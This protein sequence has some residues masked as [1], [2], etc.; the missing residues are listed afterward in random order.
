MY[1]Y[2]VGSDGEC[3]LLEF[4]LPISGR[5]CPIDG[6][7]WHNLKPHECKLI[8]L[9]S[10]ICAAFNYNHTN[11]DCIHFAVPC[12]LARDD[13]GMDFAVLTPQRDPEQCYEWRPI[14][15]RSFS[16]AVDHS[17]GYH[18]IRLFIDGRYYVGYWHSKHDEC[19]VNDGQLQISVAGHSYTCDT[20]WVKDGCTIYSLSYTLGN[21]IPARAVI[22][23]SWENGVKIYAAYLDAPGYY[24]EGMDYVQGAFK[25]SN[26]FSILVVLWDVRV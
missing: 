2:I 24:I 25:K 4:T 7:L 6:L 9:Q 12:I 26:I 1:K 16:R 19:Y 14:Q 5:Y 17:P 23:D 20:L 8:C 11:G 15:S 3:Q 18:T 21:V 13:P 10:L 22:A